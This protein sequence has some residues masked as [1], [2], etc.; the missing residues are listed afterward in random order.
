MWDNNY[1]DILSKYQKL[2]YGIAR[3]Y[4]NKGLD[5]DDLKQESLIGLLKAQQNYDPA[6]ELSFQLM[7]LTG[8][9]S[10]FTKR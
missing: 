2:A 3:L 10:S 5:W 9:K 6:E 7:L 4:R 8:I 1:D